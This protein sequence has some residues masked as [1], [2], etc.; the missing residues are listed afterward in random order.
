MGNENE[1]REIDRIHSLELIME[2]LN[3]IRESILKEQEEGW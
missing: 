3:E 2:S 1:N